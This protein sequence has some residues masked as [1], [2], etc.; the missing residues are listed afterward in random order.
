[1]NL[2]YPSTI[3]IQEHLNVKDEKVY[4]WG[5]GMERSSSSLAGWISGEVN[6]VTS[7]QTRR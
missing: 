3:R 6:L 7:A 5:I 2:K 4:G 1:V